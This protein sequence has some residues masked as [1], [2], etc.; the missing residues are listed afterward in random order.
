MTLN[1]YNIK[2][3]VPPVNDCRTAAYYGGF[4]LT[5]NLLTYRCADGESNNNI[6]HYFPFIKL[7]S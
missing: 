5:K 6:Y 3:L 7:F 4:I 1:F 2:F